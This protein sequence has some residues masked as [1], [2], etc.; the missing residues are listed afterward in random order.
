[1]CSVLLYLEV[2]LYYTNKLDHEEGVNYDTMYF[3]IYCST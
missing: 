3:W 1:M 2:P